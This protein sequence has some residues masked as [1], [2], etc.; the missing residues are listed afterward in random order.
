MD[1]RFRSTSGDDFTDQLA[2]LARDDEFLTALSQ[3]RD[4]SDGTDDVAALL[5]ELRADIETDVPPA[6]VVETGEDNVIALDS[7]RRRS[8]ALLHGLVGAAAATVL[9]AG[10]GAVLVGSGLIGAGHDDP[11]VVEL[12]GTLDEIESRAAEG[13]FNGTRELLEEARNLVAKLDR[14]GKEPAGTSRDMAPVT[15][16]GATVT[17]TPG[18]A[19][20]PEAAPVTV[21]EPGVTVTE[22][23]VVTETARETET[24]VV[25]V[26]ETRAGTIPTSTTPIPVAEPGESAGAAN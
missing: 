25:T 2:P 11:T 6:P 13:D 9:I 22:S 1:R 7:R 12:A 26:T 24:Q 5:L 17:E 8:G 3:G 21:T 19:P 14:T 20:A 16:P 10:S 15:L 23:A 4:L 18:A